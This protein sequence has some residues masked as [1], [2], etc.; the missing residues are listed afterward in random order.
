MSSSESPDAAG[1]ALQE[2][3]AS[4]ERLLQLITEEY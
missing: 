4:V 3:P 2:A 1:E